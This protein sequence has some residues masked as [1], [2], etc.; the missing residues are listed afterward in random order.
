[1]SPRIAVLIILAA[2]VLLALVSAASAEDTKPAPRRDAFGDP[3]PAGAVLRLGSARLHL[4]GPVTAI[5]WSPDGKWLAAAGA[6]DNSVPI[7][8]AVTGK[9]ICRF[10]K[11]T[12]PA[13]SVV[14]APDGKAVLSSDQQGG[15][16]LWNVASGVPLRQFAAG[17][18][19]PLAWGPSQ[20]NFAALDTRNRACLFERA[21]GR[22]LRVFEDRMTLAAVTQLASSAAG[23]L[24]VTVDGPNKVRLFDVFNGTLLHTLTPSEKVLCVAVAPDGTLLATGATDGT[25]TLW[26]AVKGKY[27]QRLRG[28]RG[29]VNGLSWSPDGKTLAS[30]SSDRTVRLWD[31]SNGRERLV[32]MGHVRAVLTV[33]FAPDGRRLASGGDEQEGIVRVWDTETGKELFEPAGHTG[34]VGMLCPLADGKTL[35]TA[36]SEGTIRYWDLAAGKYLHGFRGEQARGEVVAIAP[37]DK[38]AATGDR[39][40]MIRLFELPSGKLV[41][42]ITAHEGTVHALAFAPDGRTLASAGKDQ[43]VYLWEVATGQQLRRLETHAEIAWG[44]VFTRD[45]KHL[46]TAGGNV[47]RIWDVKTGDELRSLPRHPAYVQQIALSPDEKLLAAVSS[48]STG[49]VVELATG[50]E[51]RKLDGTDIGSCIAFSADGRSLATAARRF[52]RIWETV[53]CKERLVLDAGGGVTSLA[54]MP[55]GKTLLSGSSDGTVLVWDLALGSRETAEPPNLL[56]PADLET[57]WQHLFGPDIAR[58]YRACWTLAAVPR[59]ALPRLRIELQPV[60]IYEPKQLEQWIEELGHDRFAVRNKATMELKKAGEVAW[61]Y[62]RKV[63]ENPPSIEVAARA[64]RLLGKENQLLATADRL[65][66]ARSLEVLERLATPEAR[67]LVR[68]LAAGDPS[69]WLTREARAML[70]RMAAR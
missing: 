32:C 64:R 22:P 33:A 62:L 60:P 42:Q 40:R 14:F 7:W 28:H 36:G 10:D 61:P 18:N 54:F 52:V 15:L 26:D 19:S 31:V 39:E 6:S 12:R 25:A 43:M 35:I 5:A 9:E 2:M 29:A 37:G 50:K 34:W 38:L 69:A 13:R 63:L 46:L 47:I 11:H 3:L 27:L 56:T 45:G 68:A 59:Q 17:P 57:E 58:S 1:M 44:L 4:G 70:R 21:T 24:L 67:D 20:G 16:Y 65:R 51:V 55:D 41:R 30:A 48:D 49:R 53:T 23:E 66:Q 8:D